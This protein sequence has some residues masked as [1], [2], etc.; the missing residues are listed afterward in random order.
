MHSDKKNSAWL[1]FQY[2][3]ALIFSFITLKLN[4][5]NYGEKQFGIW[6]LFTAFWGVGSVLD[7]G[8]GTAIVKY[9]AEAKS[10]NN[11]L[12][13]NKI[14]STGFFIFAI[15]G[16]ILLFSGNI[17]AEFIYYNNKNLIAS[18]DIIKFRTV[19][20]L[21]S[22]SFYFH[23]GSSFF[24]SI[25]EGLS[26]FVF[27]S[28]CTLFYNILL[29]ISVIIVF[30]LKASITYL[31]LA[32]SISAL[33]LLIVYIFYM[34]KRNKSLLIKFSYIDYNQAKKMF[35]YSISVQIATIF[36]ALIDPSVK[37]IIGNFGSLN[38]VTFYEVARRFSLAVSGLFATSFRTFLPKSS[39]LKNRREYQ[40]FIVLE[41]I[42]LTKL[43]VGYSGFVFGCLSII[44]VFII[45]TWFGFDQSIVIFLFLSL[46]ESVNIAGFMIYSFFLGIGKATYLAI[47]QA[48]NMFLVS[49]A[50]LGGLVYFKNT[51]GFLGF[52][53]SALAVNIIQIYYLKIQ[54]GIS[55]IFYIRQSNIIKLLILHMLILITIILISYQV[56][57]AY[58]V[59]S[60]LSLVSLIIFSKEIIDYSG[61]VINYI[62][63]YTKN[64]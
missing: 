31:A 43:S 9:I 42:K 61:Q 25:F 35:G 41:G 16:S 40:D 23:Y 14:A 46:S 21:L 39:I 1:A 33:I 15:I 37:Y 52:F 19:F 2:I 62:I 50:I 58:M 53:I 4:L 28:K 47:I 10:S 24:R 29:L 7:F 57:N 44:F 60:L 55:I 32:Y 54:S 30:F 48:L 34:K 49:S 63:L 18:T 64:D 22:S 56:C 26:N 17:A 3:S 36:G 38:I 5:V 45:K 11:N 6:I 13:I 12:Q 59:L 27:T 20:V 8:F 51:L